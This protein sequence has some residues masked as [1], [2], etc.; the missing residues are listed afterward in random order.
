MNQIGADTSRHYLP[1]PIVKSVIDSMTY[2]KLVCNALIYS[3][4]FAVYSLK[5]LLI[6]IQNTSIDLLL[7]VTCN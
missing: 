3:T 2:A 5:V 6:A 7:N 4:F 1:L